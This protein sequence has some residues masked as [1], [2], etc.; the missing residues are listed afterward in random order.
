MYHRNIVAREEQSRRNDIHTRLRF[1][2]E[3][4][5]KQATNE[6]A[7]QQ[8]DSTQRIHRRDREAKERTDSDP[9]TQ[10]CLSHAGELRGDYHSQR[11]E[12][13]P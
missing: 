9:A 6:P 10:W 2:R 5:P 8:E 11:I 3:E 1:P 12:T 4:H 7:H 13:N